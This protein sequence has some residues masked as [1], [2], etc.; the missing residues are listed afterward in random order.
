MSENWE[1]YFSELEGHP[2]LVL[3]DMEAKEEIEVKEFP[4]AMMVRLSYKNP[5]I[6]GFL[7]FEKAQILDGLETQL[8]EEL[9]KHSIIIFIIH[10]I[11]IN[12][13]SCFK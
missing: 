7:F 5:D 10:V 4:I 12:S 11:T 13:R 2:A 6:N 9:E 8:Y 3:V 1:V